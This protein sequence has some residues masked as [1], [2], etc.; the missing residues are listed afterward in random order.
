MKFRVLAGVAIASLA[1]GAPVFAA[2]EMTAAELAAKN[3]AARGGADRL[4][5]LTS[6]RFDGKLIFPGDF[7]LT[8]Q[9]TRARGPKADS[10]RIDAALQG[11]TIV[12]AFDGAN[13]W[14]INPF[15]GRK[16]A[17]RMSGDEARSLADSGRLDGPMLSARAEGSTLTA[18]GREDFDGTLAYKVKVTETDGDEFVY[19]IDPDSWLEIKLTE[20]RK[21]RGAQQ[22]TEYELG[23]YEAVGGVLYPM[24]VES[25]QQGQPNQR[26]RAIIATATA[27]PVVTAALFAM[28]MGPKA[29]QGAAGTSGQADAAQ[30]AA[31]PPGDTP[32]PVTEPKPAT[33]PKG[34]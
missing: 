28:P 1:I 8:Y 15:E 24:S 12:Q 13:G 2:A 16:D 17:E 21:L 11:L 34:Q 22:V 18:L 9:E 23:D 25:W 7:Q 27:N 32:P 30:G 6:V 5:A 4:A 19:L 31:R 29:A 3:L 26:Q 10:V 20:T 14:R 33:S